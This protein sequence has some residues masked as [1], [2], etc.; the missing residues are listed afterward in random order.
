MTNDPRLEQLLDELL[1]SH[2]TPEEVC[3]SCPELL[4]EVR[5]RW[6]QICRVEAGLN[7]LFPL[8]TE[9]GM[10]PPALSLGDAALP[11]IPGY[12]V[13]ALL[14]HGGMGVVYK[15]RHL[16]LN[17]P[18]ALKMLVAGAYAGPQER[19]RFA[20]E[21]R[22][23]AALR[24]ANIVQVYDV[25]EHEGRPFFTMEFVEGG[26]LA[27]KLAGTPQPARQAATLAQTLA[28]AIAVSH[29]GGIVHRDLKPANVLL[30]ADGTPKIADFGLARRL[31]SET[32]PTQ[33]GAPLGTP[34]YMAPEQA[35]G[36]PR[37]IGPATD[38]Y[39]LGAILYEL[40]TG[41][42]PFRAETAAETVL[43]VIHQEPVP[44]SRLNARV[45]RDLETICLKCL[46]KEPQRRY[47]TAAALADDLGRFGR[48][49]PIAARPVGSLERGLRWVRRRPARAG[50]AASALALL[51]LVVGAGLWLRWERA[52]SGRVVEELDRLEQ[53]LR[54][55][56]FLARLDAI[57]L[58]RA[59]LVVGRLDMRPNKTQADQ[60]YEAAFRG[61]GLGSV[62]DDP[63]VVGARVKASKD[64]AVLVA[65]LDDWA[66]C[67]AEAADQHRQG[68]VLEVAR[69]ADPDPTGSR[70]RL[71]DP[72]AWR[73]PAAL[74]EL[75]GTALAAKPSA[76]LLVALGERLRDT[77]G[78]VI[79]FLTRVQEEYP[80]DFWANF[81]LADALGARDPGEAIR[82]YQTALAIRP[83]AA[84]AYHNLGIALA[85]C[86]RQDKAIDRYQQTL[87]IDPTYCLAHYHLGISLRAKGEVDAAIDHFQ[88]ALRI[89]P[90]L[91]LAHYNLGLALKTKGR[92][93]EAIDHFR[94]A[95]RIS[96]QDAYTHYN[97]G[98]ALKERG[99]PD[100]A[101]GH[102][103]LALQ[104]NPGHIDAHYN[105]ALA[106]A[107]AG[108]VDEAMDHF[109]RTIQIEPNHAAAHTHLGLALK[110][111]GQL[112]AAILEFQHALRI[113][114]TD[115][116]THNSLGLALVA[117]HRLDEAIAHYEKAIELNPRFGPAHNNCAL[118]LKAKGQRDEAI[119]H[120]KQALR[121]NREDAFAHYHLGLIL[122]EAGRAEEAI[123]HFRQ[124]LGRK[125]S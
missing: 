9:P 52:V 68:W 83:G 94:Q 20:R 28:E 105:L 66:V 87:R 12:Q 88:Q 42:P 5:A 92:L 7:A 43:Q 72:A 26:S 13:E 3:S 48:G 24:H 2:C 49:E 81:T 38:V 39:A 78:D 10:P 30:T 1:D 57:H 73:N 96:P 32:G 34:G 97:L 15:A 113:D 124:A 121:I 62:H 95:L 79:P 69:R 54:D 99:R 98:L 59:A 35:A 6:R 23:A 125:G 86:S 71:R 19:A 25:A 109:R 91:G 47:T 70:H 116:Y 84:V 123:D 119:K 58:S 74:A 120:F 46:H 115:A 77:G 53:A 36:K 82:Y 122:I 100:E 21:A 27:Q 22:A 85:A 44:P 8:P 80:G 89:D 50:L 110:D 61:A 64:R 102:Y 51:G 118:A 75:I 29:Q 11:Q 60:E 117:Q 55:Q 37:A 107:E 63:D 101:I 114:A 40:L 14:G 104:I 16:R 93:D 45:P 18:V 103:T 33:T 112:D 90:G 65:A 17:R 111:R 76:H 108:R 106:L 67:A 56:E 41:Q 31:Q 4:P